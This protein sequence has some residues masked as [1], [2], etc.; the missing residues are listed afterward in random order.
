VANRGLASTKSL[1]LS[2]IHTHDH[3]A[4]LR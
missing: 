1:K 3:F 4:F 2:A